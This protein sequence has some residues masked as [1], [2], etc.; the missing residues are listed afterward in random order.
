MLVP[1]P[2][3]LQTAWLFLESR[4]CSSQVP[5]IAPATPAV[6]DRG[7]ITY[8]HISLSRASV[9]HRNN[10]QRLSSSWKL[11]MHTHLTVLLTHGHPEEAH[12]R[13]DRPMPD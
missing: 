13:R 5:A 1:L 8:S 7:S 3:S 6:T 9:C 12:A 10:Y 4:C 2:E 11:L